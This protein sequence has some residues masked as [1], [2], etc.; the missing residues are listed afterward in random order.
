MKEWDTD[1]VKRVTQCYGPGAERFVEFKAIGGTDG[2]ALSKDGSG[3]AHVEIV[4]NINESRLLVT[5]TLSFQFA[6]ESDQIRSA[7]WTTVHE[8]CAPLL[9]EKQ[10]MKRSMESSSVGGDLCNHF[11]HPSVISLDADKTQY[12]EAVNSG[13]HGPGMSI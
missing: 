10:E 6:P 11:V 8:Y 3:F 9:Q 1:F 13:M 4:L 2:I 5:A 7:S 12:D